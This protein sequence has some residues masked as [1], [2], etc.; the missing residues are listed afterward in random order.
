MPKKS[1]NKMKTTLLSVQNL[2]VYYDDVPALWNVNIEVAEDEMIALVGS[3]GA[4]KSTLL[5]TLSGLIKPRRG[6]IV[7]NG[8]NLEHMPPYDIVRNGVSQVPEGRRLFSGLSVKDNLIMGAYLKRNT[9]Q[10][11]ENLDKIFHM[12]PRLKERENQLA[13]KLSGG[14]QQMCSIGRALMAN[15]KLLL[16]DELSLGLAPVIVDELIDTLRKL[17]GNGVTIILVEQDIETALKVA[18]RGYV[19]ENGS[20]TLQGECSFLL[21]ND[22]VRAA[23][24]G[25]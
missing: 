12:F 15:P 14:E 19:I 2:D 6:K 24:L 11:K 25:I 7:F 5:R 3:N 18:D 4:G 21:M 16:I 1:V 8:I 22:H 23:Y 10:V 13:G 9:A 17:K 20:V